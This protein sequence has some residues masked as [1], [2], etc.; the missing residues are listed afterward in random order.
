MIDFPA[1]AEWLEGQLAVPADSINLEFKPQWCKPGFPY[2][3]AV[4]L[5]DEVEGLAELCHPYPPGC[6][7]TQGHTPEEACSNMKNKIWK[8]VGKTGVVYS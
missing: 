3:L 2:H 1:L 6:C 8:H 4:S 5:P 7:K